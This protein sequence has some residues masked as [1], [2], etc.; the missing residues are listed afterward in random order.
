MGQ[1]F[2][3]LL[4]LEAAP[5]IGGRTA[6]KCECDCGNKKDIKTEELRSG[7]TK[8]CGCWNNEQRSARAEKMYSACI[9]YTPQEAS[10]RKIWQN[11]YSEIS[12]EDFFELSQ[13]NCH[14]CDAPPSNNQNAA[15]GK[16]SSENIKENGIFNYNGLD[17]VDNTL[18]HTK[19][20]C[21]PCCKYCNFA[22]RERT[23]EEF[24]TW[25]NNLY[26]N[27]VK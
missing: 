11:R 27:L 7:G 1:K 2:N 18:P 13:Q 15:A 8:S 6:W 22:K 9:K 23:Q 5:S 25:I 20:N 16:N 19:E 10:A 12:F 21:V 17:R 26:E 4:V 24:R 14:Y 3:R